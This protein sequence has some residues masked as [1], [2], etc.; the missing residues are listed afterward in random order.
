MSRV[1]IALLAGLVIGMAVAHA[2]NPALS[3][4]VALLEPIGSIWINGIRMT[5]VPLVVSLLLAAVCRG[6]DASRVGRLGGLSFGVFIALH[7]AAALIALAVIPGI[8]TYLPVDAASVAR[9]T[10]VRTASL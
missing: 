2:R 1:V 5:V 6:G 8:M 10:G 9:P 4:A 7:V 3:R